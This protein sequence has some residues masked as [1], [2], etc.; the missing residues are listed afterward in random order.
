[1]SHKGSQVKLYLTE[2]LNSDSRSSALLV[3]SVAA[4]ILF[5]R[6]TDSFI[7]PQFWA[8]DGAIFFLQQYENGPSALF[9]EYAGY[10]NLVPRLI[11]LIADLFFPYSAIPAFYNYSSLLLTLCVLLSIFSPR[12]KVKHKPLIAL[13]IVLIPHYTNEVFLTIT[14]LQWILALML[15]VVLLK[16]KPDHRYGNIIVQ[17]AFDLATI[18][19]CGLTGPFLIFLAP[20]YVW[21]WVTDKNRYNSV[22]LIAVVA[23]SSIQ[24]GFIA[25]A[26]TPPQDTVINLKAYSAVIGHRLFGNLFLGYII[27]SQ[28]SH[29]V[30]SFLY[31]VTLI[32]IVRLAKERFI[33]FCISIHL[34]LL[35]ATFYKFKADPEILFPPANGPRYFYLPYIMLAWSLIALLGQQGKWKNTLLTIALTFILISSLTSRFH[36][37]PFIDYKWRLYSKS[38]GKEDAVIPI[39]PKGWQIHIRADPQLQ[40]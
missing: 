5:I 31:L 27:G 32:L 15:I 18:I 6:K 19:I 30:L 2:R 36:S 34:V 17:Y 26:S 35:L 7:N 24:L 25:S 22:I 37:A 3:L 12:F 39:N 23:V 9:Q 1:M 40:Q 13:T 16:E 28:I 20:F 8:E 11:A 14:N 10:L 4:L 38:I 29:Y 21:K 33:F